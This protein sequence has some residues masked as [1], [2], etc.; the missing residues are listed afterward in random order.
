[1]SRPATLDDGGHPAGSVQRWTGRLAVIGSLCLA[2]LVVGS[3]L[4][5]LRSGTARRNSYATAGVLQRVLDLR[6]AAKVA[7]NL[8]PFL[9]I[10]CAVAVALV[11]LG[12]RRG[13]A[14]LGLLCAAAAGLVSARALAV[15]Q[16][17]NVA[18]AHTGPVVTLLFSLAALAC[19]AGILA[20][21]ALISRSRR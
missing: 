1:V 16:R 6:G 10:C 15:E 21:P 18:V 11:A 4:P 12:A 3:F 13:G 2:G 5:W 7:L 14:V 19:F 9:A 17:L 20:V 8:W